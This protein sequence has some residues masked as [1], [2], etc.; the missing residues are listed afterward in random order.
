[1]VERANYD[2]FEEMLTLIRDLSLDS[3]GLTYDQIAEKLGCSRK[4][5][6]RKI[7]F[8]RQY[9]EENLEEVYDN[10]NPR[11]KR[12]FFT[13]PLQFPRE[14]LTEDKIIALDTAIKKI[15]DKNISS[16]LKDLQYYLKQIMSFRSENSHKMDNL[17]YKSLN[18]ECVLNPHPHIEIDKQ[19]LEDAKDAIF[20]CQKL[21]C[22]Y[23]KSNGEKK[24]YTLCPLGILYGSSNDYLVAYEDKH[25]NIPKQFI[26]SNFIK[27]KI[28]DSG[29]KNQFKTGAFNLQNYA[30]ESFGAYHTNEKP[31]NIE[32]RASANVAKDAERYTFH[33]TQTIIKNANG[34][35]TIKF[36]ANGLYEMVTY[37]FQ[38]RGEIVPVKPKELV[39]TYKNMLDTAL[40]SLEKQ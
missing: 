17:G 1:M 40:K 7:S 19:I 27:L 10:Q 34:T 3:I 37:L 31:L 2:K 20:Y 6:E 38:W 23:K 33:P 32:W 39:D 25:M 13:K 5:A 21:D 30:N 28:I 4:K 29:T 36:K 16:P 8:F 18:E 11:T 14:H 24:T 22:L 35:L 12:F 15:K 26:L 9:F